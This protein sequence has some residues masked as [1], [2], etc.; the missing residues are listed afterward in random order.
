MGLNITIMPKLTPEISNAQAHTSVPTLIRES[1]PPPPA[2]FKGPNPCIVFFVEC[3][4][5]NFCNAVWQK[6]LTHGH[7][8]HESSH[9]GHHYLFQLIWLCQETLDPVTTQRTYPHATLVL[10]RPA[11]LF[12]S[13]DTCHLRCLLLEEYELI[14]L[15]C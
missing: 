8:Q 2:H 11:E 12:V 1:P 6:A 5:I 9:E 3:S 4:N 13:L 10:H 14:I 7:A 15:L